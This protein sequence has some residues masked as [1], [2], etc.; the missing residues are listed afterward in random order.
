ML[1]VAPAC[2]STTQEARQD[3]SQALVV[4]DELE[5]QR[6]WDAARRQLLAVAEHAPPHEAGDLLLWRCD[7]FRFDLPAEARPCYLDLAKASRDKDPDVEALAR[8]HAAGLAEEE[9]Q[10]LAELLTLVLELPAQEPARRALL[11][12]AALVEQVK[13]REAAIRMLRETAEAM[14]QARAEPAESWPRALREL[15]SQ[16]WTLAAQL[17][18]R[19]DDPSL[20]LELLER[21]HVA[22]EGTHWHDD[23]L[24]LEAR[25]L[26]QLGRPAEAVPVYEEIKEARRSSWIVGSYDSEYFDD[27][28]Y[29]LAE[30]LFALGR[31]AEAEE[32]IAD[33]EDDAPTSRLRDDAAFLA[34]RMAHGRGDDARLRRFVEDFPESRHVVEARRLLSEAP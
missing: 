23:A 18:A 5:R 31:A 29:E 3:L 6:A 15:V 17:A 30:T 1:A 16:A 9:V 10:A 7:L 11:R 33:L 27:A 4:A 24:I 22:T 20:T 34:A 14:E 21:A 8:W 25:T 32:V 13:G 26:R 19:G 28:L 2:A 12:A